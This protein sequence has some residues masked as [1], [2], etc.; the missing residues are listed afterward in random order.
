M[1]RYN[2]K[3]QGHLTAVVW[4]DKREVYMLRNMNQPSAEGKF[5]W[6]QESALKPPTVEHNKHTQYV[7]QINWM[8]DCYSMSQC[9]FKW[10]TQLFP[11]CWTL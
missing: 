8:A 11:T 9:T 10:M 6:W 3:D 7:D 1:G 4:E 5:L 2:T